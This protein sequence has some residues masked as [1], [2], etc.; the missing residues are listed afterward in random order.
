MIVPVLKFGGCCAE[1]IALYERAF[2]ISYKHA[3]YYRDAPAGS[4]LPVDERT[5]DWIM[6]CDLTLCGS[7][8][9]MSDSE[10]GVAP[11]HPVILNALISR[12]EVEK[13]YR[14]LSEEG[15]VVVPLGPQFFSPL[16]GSVRDR[17]GIHW[18]LVAVS[19]E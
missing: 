13:A 11:D 18:Q 12:G 19:P 8:L 16:Y 2:D 9:N 4:G 1:A 10:D 3:E 6:H 15:E 17:Y 7:L 14:V 5:R